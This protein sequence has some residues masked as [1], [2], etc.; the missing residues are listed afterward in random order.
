MSEAAE[1]TNGIKESV[2]RI[3]Q[4]MEQDAMSKQNLAYL[5]NR[6]VSLREQ[7]LN[8]QAALQEATAEVE[9]LNALLPKDVEPEE[10]DTEEESPVA[11][12]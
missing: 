8:L 9:R 6:V 11:D 1:P 4:R 7:V 2:N 10:G 3:A 5:S 12:E